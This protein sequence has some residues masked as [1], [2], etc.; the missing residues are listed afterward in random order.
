M[1]CNQSFFF[2]KKLQKHLAFTHKGQK[3][4]ALNTT[5]KHTFGFVQKKKAFKKSKLRVFKYLPKKKFIKVYDS[6]FFGNKAFTQKII[7]D[8]RSVSARRKKKIRFII[9]KVGRR[10]EN[11]HTKKRQKMKKRRKL[12]RKKR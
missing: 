8:K 1:S 6:G 12:K 11:M 9:E 2:L 10:I 5:Q 7:E 3:R 4:G